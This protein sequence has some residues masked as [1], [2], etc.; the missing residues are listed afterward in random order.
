[1]ILVVDLEAIY[2][3]E[4]RLDSRGTKQ[5]KSSELSLGVSL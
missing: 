2:V 3:I 1:M 5:N 4:P